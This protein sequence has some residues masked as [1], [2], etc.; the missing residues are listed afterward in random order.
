LA[1][2]VGAFVV[3]DVYGDTRESRMIGFIDIRAALAAIPDGYVHALRHR[4]WSQA[5]QSGPARDRD[6]QGG[7]MQARRIYTWRRAK[8]RI[9]IAK[10]SQF[11]TSSDRIFSTIS[12]IE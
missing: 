3:V 10:A 11:A 9:L 6:R 5:H 7:L 8:K 1:I 4:A 2:K 12:P